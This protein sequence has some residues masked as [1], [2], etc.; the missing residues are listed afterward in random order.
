MTVFFVFFA[1]IF[2]RKNLSSLN[3]PD[4][5]ERFN[6]LYLNIDTDIPH[7]YLLTTIFLVRRFLF[8]IILSFCDDRQDVQFFY[9]NFTS[10]LIIIY[11]IKVRPLVSCYLNFI[12]IFNEVILYGCTGLIW[13]MTDYQGDR[14][15][16][17]TSEQMNAAYNSK[18]NQI[19]WAYIIMAS[20]TIVM[21]IG[22]VIIS[23][24][25]SIITKLKEKC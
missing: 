4:F 19:G 23:S 8:G 9:M 18:Q 13:G 24:L 12:E 2:L 5:K 16:G 1:H 20:T 3:E 17:L 14:L 15:D 25:I 21:A 7:S 10:F 6:S 22:G 11:L